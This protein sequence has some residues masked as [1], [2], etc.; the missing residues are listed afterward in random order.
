MKSAAPMRA[1]RARTA[2]LIA[3]GVTPSSAAARRKLRCW[4]TLRN[5]STPS[6]AP[7]LTV[8]FC[9][10]ARHLYR[11]YSLAES[12][13]TSELPIRRTAPFHPHHSLHHGPSHRTTLTPALHPPN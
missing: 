9:F 3:D 6:S 11:E 5:A 4:A 8:K 1:S 10:I 13:L 12:G 7:F 2:W